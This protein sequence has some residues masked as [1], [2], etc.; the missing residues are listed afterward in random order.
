MELSQTRF[1]DS[2]NRPRRWISLLRDIRGH[3]DLDRR[4]DSLK[5]ACLVSGDGTRDFSS[6]SPALRE[7]PFPSKPS[8]LDMCH[9]HGRPSCSLSLTSTGFRKVGQLLQPVTRVSCDSEGHT[10]LRLGRGPSAS[11]PPS[12]RPRPPL[13]KRL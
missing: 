2:R 10:E 3:G 9:A 1:H 5:A 4:G 8:G 12:L 11:L 13:K 7:Q 6:T